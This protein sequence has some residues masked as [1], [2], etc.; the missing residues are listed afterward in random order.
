VSHDLSKSEAKAADLTQQTFFV[1]AKKS[2]QIRDLSKVKCWL[3]TTIRR[4]FLRSVRS[5]S[6][7]PHVEFR[8]D[9]HDS[10]SVEADAVRALDA[11]SVMEALA[12][13]DETYRNALELF[14][15]SER[16]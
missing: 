5:Q 9:V 4:E 7:H 11:K 1:L 10:P 13:V 2:H 6:N 16:S 15:L 3:F 12:R 14:Y 8:P